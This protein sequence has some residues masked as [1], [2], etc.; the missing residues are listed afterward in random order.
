MVAEDIAVAL[1]TSTRA[2]NTGRRQGR[3]GIPQRPGPLLHLAFGGAPDCLAVVTGVVNVQQALFVLSSINT[4]RPETKANPHT[5]APQL[6]VLIPVDIFEPAVSSV[7]TSAQP[8]RSRLRT[9]C[10]GCSTCSSGT[11]AP[12]VVVELLRA[13]HRFYAASL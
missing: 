1:P 13:H 5:H 4:V 10:F 6:W 2:R 9:L 8:R 7:Q 12:E 11:F 3:T